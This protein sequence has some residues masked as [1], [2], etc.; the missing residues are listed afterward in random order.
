MPMICAILIAYDKK[1]EANFAIHE[2]FKRRDLNSIKFSEKPNRLDNLSGF[3]CIQPLKL[4]DFNCFLLAYSEKRF[5]HLKPVIQF[6]FR[7]EETTNPVDFIYVI[8][9]FSISISMVR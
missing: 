1:R 7:A 9:C 6:D 2:V 3:L 4:C 8:N 5:L